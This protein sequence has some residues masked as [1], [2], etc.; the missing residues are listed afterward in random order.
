MGILRPNEFAIEEL[1]NVVELD[2]AKGDP[3]FYFIYSNP[4]DAMQRFQQC[5]SDYDDAQEHARIVAAR[6]RN[7][8]AQKNYRY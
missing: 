3:Y 4:E 8:S 5:A 6:Q 2:D 1:K 7:K